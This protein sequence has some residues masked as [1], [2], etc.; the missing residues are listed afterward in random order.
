MTMLRVAAFL[1]ALNV[2]GRRV[3]NDQLVEA[4]VGAGFDGATA[5][6]ASGNLLLTT[7]DAPGE[8]AERL[9]QALAKHLGF[10]TEVFLR[11]ADE[12]ATALAAQ[13][14]SHQQAAE[15]TS[16]PQLM[17]LTD[18]LSQAQ[19]DAVTELTTD[20]D[21]LVV[22]GREIHWLPMAGVGRSALNTDALGRITGATTV[23]T[24]GTVAR[25]HAKLTT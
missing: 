14:F 24:T 19:T 7:P 13:P 18:T 4:A 15:A 9:E 3:T 21:L 6:Q 23:R 8:T 1:R 2:G 11:T 10:T 12:L 25:I 22:V 17:F 20:N 5:Y 16:A